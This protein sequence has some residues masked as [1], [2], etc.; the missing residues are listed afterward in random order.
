M[1]KEERLALQSLA[2]IYCEMCARRGIG[3]SEIFTRLVIMGTLP[4]AAC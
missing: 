2:G 4:A 3:E 1:M